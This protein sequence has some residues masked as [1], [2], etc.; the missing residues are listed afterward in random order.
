M[1]I[2]IQ[3]LNLVLGGNPVL[4]E[5][6]AHVPAGSAV[7][8]VGPSGAGKTS[9]LR[10]LAGLAIPTSG[11]VLLDRK[12]PGHYHGTGRLGFLFQ[13]ACL[14]PHLTIRENLE[15]V[16][17]AN[18]LPADVAQIERQLGAVGMVNEGG[19]YPHEC[20]VGMRARAAIARS[21]CLPPGL[22]LM[23]E[24]FAALDP[25]RRLELNRNV[26]KSRREQGITLVWV[27][28]DVVEALMFADFILGL[29]SRGGNRWYDRRNVESIEDAGALPA[30]ARNL[31]D[32]IIREMMEAAP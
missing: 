30:S 3:G 7:A 14:C 5:L 15:L 18:R 31:R 29:N 20:S 11:E 23:D 17:W 16:Y 21:L 1:Q 2:D 26:A 28:H 32:E 4:R 22:L 13:E 27:S 24:P 19:K 12:P 10:V 9:L 6:A 8:V 25:I